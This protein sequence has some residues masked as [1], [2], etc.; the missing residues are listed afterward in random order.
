MSKTTFKPQQQYH[1]RWMI[2]RDMTDILRIELAAFSEFPWD[3][4]SFVRR[5]RQRNCIGM[6]AEANFAGN[7][8]IVGYMVYELHRE[9]IVVL[10]FAVDPRFHRNGVGTAMVE[11]LKSKLSMNR[12]RCLA[13]EARES[14]LDALNFFKSQGFRAVGLLPNYYEECNEDAVLMRYR[15]PTCK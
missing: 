8:K 11:K 5:L 10:N 7:L 1:I 4:E 2:R 3:E 14:N 12:R 6:T 15:M 9:R 13:L